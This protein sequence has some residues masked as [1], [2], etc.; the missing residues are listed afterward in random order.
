MKFFYIDTKGD[1]GFP[2]TYIVSHDNKKV[3]IFKPGLGLAKENVYVIQYEYVMGEWVLNE[4]KPETIIPAKDI[5]QMEELDY[6]NSS[7][8]AGY[9]WKFNSK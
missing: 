8:P 4:E 6:T 1:E 3:S 9:E 2:H 5:H 7:L